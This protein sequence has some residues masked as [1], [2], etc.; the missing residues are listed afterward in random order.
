MDRISTT[1]RITHKQASDLDYYANKM[2]LSRNQLLTN[3]ISVELDDLALLDKLGI[4][5]I[6][7]GLRD[8]LALAKNQDDLNAIEMR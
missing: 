8:L 1:L 4:L 7:A 2:G 5:R 3:L 6:G